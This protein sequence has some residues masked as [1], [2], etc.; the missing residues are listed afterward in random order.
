M[1]N[2]PIFKK[3]YSD[4]LELLSKLDLQVVAKY[5]GCEWTGDDIVI[6]F[7]GIYYRIS[8][9]GIFDEYGKEPGHH[10]KVVLCQYVL[11]HPKCFPSDNT[12]VSYKDFRDAAPFVYA[13]HNNVEQK[14]AGH[15]IGKTDLLRNVCLRAGG[16][17]LNCEWDYHLC[18]KFNAL[19]MIP[20]LLLFNDAEELFPAQCI[21]LFE[22]K[23]EKYL[24]MESLAILGGLLVDQ[25]ILT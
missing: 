10:V 14:I 4:Y 25:L 19:P 22:R 17:I 5:I 16:C 1:T 6:P 3:T 20:I 2:A 21:L 8:Q 9:S 15:F 12:W 24:D 18:M 13:F 7:F 23:A 11:R